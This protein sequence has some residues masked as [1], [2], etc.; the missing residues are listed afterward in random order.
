MFTFNLKTK[1][2][3]GQPVKSALPAELAALG[4]DRVLLVSDPG[5]HRAFE[6]SGRCV[7]EIVAA[8]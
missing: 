5:L 2:V 4:V 1:I 6:A 8:I 3:F 7:L